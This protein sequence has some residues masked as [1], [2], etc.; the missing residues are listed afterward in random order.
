MLM[1]ILSSSYLI[2]ENFYYEF[3]KH[4][5]ISKFCLQNTEHVI[6]IYKK[7]NNPMQQRRTHTKNKK[8]FR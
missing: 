7:N 8:K 4:Q 5:T 3:G 6:F 1:R 2:S